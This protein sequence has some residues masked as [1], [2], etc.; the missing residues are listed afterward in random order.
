MKN[1]ACIES[2]LLPLALVDCISNPPRKVGIEALA[3]AR[4]VLE[5]QRKHRKEKR[6]S[7]EAKALLRLVE[8]RSPALARLSKL[9]IHHKTSIDAEGE[10]ELGCELFP[11]Q[12]NL[13]G[14]LDASAASGRELEA[15]SCGESSAKPR[16]E[17]FFFFFFSSLDST[18]SLLRESI[19]CFLSSLHFSTKK[20]TCAPATVSRTVCMTSLV[21]DIVKGRD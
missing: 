21:A 2:Q 10:R 7:E 14:A 20:L 5:R 19:I 1:F 15:R 18:K 11:A 4:L 3:K 8:G 6:A 16:A 12:G 9:L 13:D 17:N